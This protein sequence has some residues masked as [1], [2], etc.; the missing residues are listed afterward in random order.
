MGSL[1]VNGTFERTRLTS[2][3]GLTKNT[4]YFGKQIRHYLCTNGVTNR[5]GLAG[6]TS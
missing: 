4:I 2:R 5:G 3:Y 1:D 6:Q